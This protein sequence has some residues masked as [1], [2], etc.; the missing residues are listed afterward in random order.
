MNERLVATSAVRCVGNVLLLQGR[1]YSPPFVITAVG[2]GSAVRA[3]LAASPQVAILQQA[4]D[5][6]GLTFTVHD[7]SSVSLPAYSGSLDM[8][9]ATPH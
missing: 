2:S 9:Y 4:V 1:T 7:R 3:Q 8:E 6:F 5:A